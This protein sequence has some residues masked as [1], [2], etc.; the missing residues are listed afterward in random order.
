[1]TTDEHPIHA[2]AL[3]GPAARPK[4][5]GQT[6]LGSTSERSRRSRASILEFVHKDEGAD[7]LVI[8]NMWP[9][10]ERPVYGIFVQRQVE[11]LR[12]RGLRCDVLYLRGYASPLAYPR[13]ALQFLTASTAWRRRYR[14][15]HVHAGE[16]GLA[17]RF[18][19]GVPMLVSYW[20]DDVLGDQRD[21]GHISRT[22]RIRA[23]VIRAHAGLFA[24]TI[25]QST[26]M[27]DRLP[28]FV[29]RKNSVLPAGVDPEVFK[30]IERSEARALVGW[31]ANER[32]ALFAAMKPDRKRRG[33]AE[34]ACAHASRRLGPVRLHV[35][36]QTPPR[37]MPVLMNACDCLVHT[38]SLEGSPNVVKE[39]LMCNLPVVATP[40]GDVEDLL[41]G[42]TPSYVCRPVTAEIGEA[43][44][45]CLM[46]G[47]RSDGRAKAT[48]T[49]SA[50]V[51][52]SQLFEI[53]RRFG[54]RVAHTD[55]FG[56]TT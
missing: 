49:L 19:L 56:G 27:H 53:Y 28:P 43:I 45:D 3:L 31:D 17:A 20:G 42:V 51:G 52:A 32:V 4:L 22:S 23:A 14:L 40:A 21:D 26:E 48:A 54:V 34:A 33:L 47:I 10:A 13:A 39:A 35:A 6:A 11:S 55:G 18:F 7:V 41:K 2:S 16:T 38:A 29:R 50:D 24:A 12:A 36:S 9:D 5:T 37:L 44:V 25:T 1:M 8:T 30:P 46:Q 15:V